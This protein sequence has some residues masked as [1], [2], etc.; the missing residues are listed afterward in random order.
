M[1]TVDCDIIKDLLPSYS[2]K[3]LS[4][5]SNKLVEEH[6]QKCKTCSEAFKNMNKDINTNSLFEQD[7]Q[8]DYLKGYRNKK[9]K[10][11]IFSIVLTILI[12][13]TVLI[14]ALNFFQ[15]AKFYVDVNSLDIVYLGKEK[16]DGIDTLNFQICDKKYDL[17][18]YQ[19][20]I[21]E[22]T[23]GKIIYV[24]TVGKC[25]FGQTARCYCSIEIDETVE[26]IY[27]ED[28]KGDLKEIWNKNVF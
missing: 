19:Y 20:E 22:N 27:L 6:L 21:N 16:Y 2:D 26:R 3:I 8:I 9:L 11:V 4:D 12:L 17:E 10:S 24:K 7:E 23:N 15:Y 14:S 25:P 5:S 13:L 18:F 1:K 28:K